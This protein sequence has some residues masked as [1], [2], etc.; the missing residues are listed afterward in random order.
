MRRHSNSQGLAIQSSAESSPISYNMSASNCA[1]KRK[2][3]AFAS[4][5]ATRMTQ[6]MFTAP[7]FLRKEHLRF[8][9]N[10]PDTFTLEDPGS[11]L[12]LFGFCLI[13]PKIT[14]ELRC[15]EFTFRK[16]SSLLGSSLVFKYTSGGRIPL[17]EIITDEACKR[18]LLCFLAL[19]SAMWFR[20]TQPQPRHNFMMFPCEDK[21]D[22]DAFR[23]LCNKH[24][25]I[26]D[27]LIPSLKLGV[28]DLIAH[29]EECY[30]NSMC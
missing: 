3:S 14:L 19:K 5:G 22:R 20:S 26:R 17:I 15:P 12:G 28:D 2:A 10:P 30:V 18:K 7:K 13:H 29:A 25:G 4:L 27:L 6:F 1:S 23:D 8:V 21:L 11:T 24:P 9:Y 16:V